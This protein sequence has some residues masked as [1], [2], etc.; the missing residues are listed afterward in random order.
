MVIVGGVQDEFFNVRPSK[1]LRDAVW[2]FVH[3]EIIPNESA[4][5]AAIAD[6]DRW[7]APDS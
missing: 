2:S 5:V 3:D 6:G 7:A 1:G 4:F